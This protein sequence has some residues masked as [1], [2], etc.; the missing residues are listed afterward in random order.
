MRESMFRFYQLQILLLLSIG[1]ITGCPGQGSPNAPNSGVSE[2]NYNRGYQDGYSDDTYY[3]EGFDDSYNDHLYMASTYPF[4][5]ELSYITGLWDGRFDA[6]N[7]GYFDCYHYAFVVGFSEGYDRGFRDDYLEF[8]FRDLH[9][10]YDDGSWDDGYEDGFSEGRVLG[11]ADF[12]ELYQFDWLAT[13]IEYE[14]GF[15][16]EFE[17]LG[18]GVGTIES[19]YPV[20]TIYELGQDPLSKKKLDSEEN[21]SKAV[22]PLVSYLDFYFPTSDRG[23]EIGLTTTWLERIDLWRSY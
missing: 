20:I 5:D 12:I 8:L 22:D 11:A 17:Y 19:A 16:Y 6:Y 21:T 9:F 18:R 1:I 14:E 7:E 23:G 13:L 15:D 4:L 10:E 2:A 3:W